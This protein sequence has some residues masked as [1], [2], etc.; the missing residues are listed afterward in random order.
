MGLEPAFAKNTAA[1]PLAGFGAWPTEPDDPEFAIPR[2]ALRI[3]A[4][5]TADR[6]YLV[7]QSPLVSVRASEPLAPVA[8][9][10]KL[11]SRKWL[12]AVM[13][14]CALH[15]AVAMFFIMRS[16]DEQVLIEGS[17]NAGITLLGNAAEDQSAAVD[18]SEFDPS[19]VT[20]VTMVTM[21]D[22]KPVETIEAQAVAQP[23]TIEA[24]EV[25]AVE[26]PVTE[27]I[28]P[29]SD[30]P[31]QPAVT[32][33]LPE[34]LATDTLEPVEDDNIVQKPVELTKAEPVEIEKPEPSAE[35]EAIAAEVDPAPEPVKKPLEKPIRKAEAKPA[36]K[37]ENKAEQPKKADKAPARQEKPARTGSGGSGQ[38]DTRKGEADGAANGTTTTKGKNGNSATAGNAAVSNYPGKVLAKLRRALRGI[39]RGVRAKAQNDVH[40]GFVVDAAGGVGGVR[41]VR[42]SGSPELDRAAVEMVRRAAPFPPIPPE[43]GRSSWQFTLPLGVAG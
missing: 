22:A 39:S 38:A 32:S 29:I 7:D 33:P 24:V 17:A 16:N 43:A 13:A 3:C 6:T 28:Q 37:P 5:D 23:E 10:V 34:I 2:G 41:V 18:L 12:A 8:T 15:A 4:R 11:R 42:S 20:N 40:V 31:I 27:T 14:S 26:T 35:A 21:L 9:L 36:K 19:T 25:V 1:W 30:Q